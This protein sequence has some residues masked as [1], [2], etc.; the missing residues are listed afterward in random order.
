MYSFNLA[1]PIRI[2]MSKYVESKV[3]I[4]LINENP[5]WL[6]WIVFLSINMGP[7]HMQ[8]AASHHNFAHNLH[9]DDYYIQIQYIYT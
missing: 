6:F 5:Q 8:N 2:S 7:Y 4:L 3:F 1:H 9:S